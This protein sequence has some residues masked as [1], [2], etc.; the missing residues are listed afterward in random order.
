MI[1]K[2]IEDEKKPVAIVGENK[3][4]FLYSDLDKLIELFANS[5]EDIIFECL[6]DDFSY[7]KNLLEKIYA[8]TKKQD[9]IDA[10]QKV[11]KINSKEN[12]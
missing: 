11:K 2:I 1:I 5:N 12:E 8:E 10:Y 9:F 4:S 7:Y 6:I 3:Y